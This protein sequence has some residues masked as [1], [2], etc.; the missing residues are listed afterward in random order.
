MK[1][2]YLMVATYIFDCILIRT[3]PCKYF[4]LNSP[5]FNAEEGIFSKLDI[6]KLIPAKWRLKQDLVANCI[7]PEDF[8]VFIKPE[9]G[10]NSNGIVKADNQSSYNKLRQQLKSSK[11]KYLVQQAAPE[12]QEFEIFSILS[13]E[14]PHRY[15]ELTIT[16]VDNSTEGYPVNSIYNPDT[17]YREITEEFSHAEKEKIWQLMGEIK[18]FG[19][20]RVGLRANCK[21]SLLSGK[22]HIIEINLFVPMPINMLDSRY[23]F[24]D[25]WQFVTRYMMSLALITRARDKSL[26]QKPVFTKLMLYNRTNPVLNFFREQL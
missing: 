7:Q 1:I 4:Q 20:A 9:W 14:N 3:K 17:Q 12:T 10:Q 11:V 5:Y 21:E 13:H 19:I 26:K 18:R 16:R 25:L 22:F 23:N 8:P 15:S 2:T 6:D 24:Y